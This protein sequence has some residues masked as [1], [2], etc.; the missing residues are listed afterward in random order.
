MRKRRPTTGGGDGNGSGTENFTPGQDGSLT[1]NGTQPINGK[2]ILVYVF[3]GH[4]Y[5]GT[6]FDYSNTLET[7]LFKDK[8]V[9]KEA[10]EFICEKVCV[11]DHELLRKVKG[12]EAIADYFARNMAKPEQRKVQLL[13]LDATGAPI[14][15]FTDPK[16]IKEGAPALLKAMRAAREENAKRLALA[17]AKPAPAKPADAPADAPAGAPANPPANNDPTSKSGG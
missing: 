1:W 17:A 6:Q 3:N 2:P 8:D 7:V 5:E 4:I 12:R 16:A 10:R 11:G 9:I 15:A 13:F 14:S